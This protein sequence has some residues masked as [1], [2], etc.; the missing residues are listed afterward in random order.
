MSLIDDVPDEYLRYSS[1]GEIEEGYVKSPDL[2]VS[3]DILINRHIYVNNPMVAW[4]VINVD[5]QCYQLQALTKNYYQGCVYGA[6]QLVTF[7]KNLIELDF[8][9]QDREEVF[10]TKTF[11]YNRMWSDINQEK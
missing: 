11:K 6:G 8:V 2:F 10:Q 3:G 9:F 4:K 1:Y 5:Q 7:P